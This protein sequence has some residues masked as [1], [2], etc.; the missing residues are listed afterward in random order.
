MVINNEKRRRLLHSLITALIVD[1]E[2]QIRVFMFGYPQRNVEG[3][4]VLTEPSFGGNKPN[5]CINKCRSGDCNG[6]QSLSV[7]RSYEHH[8]EGKSERRH[9]NLRLLRISRLFITYFHL[10]NY[11]YSRVWR[12]SRLPPLCCSVT[13]PLLKRGRRY[14][15]PCLRP[16][17]S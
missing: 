6:K 13:Q 10:I 4:L 1:K 14:G 7:A 5:W 8:A 15:W 16:C 17:F 12:N 3:G 2:K 11:T 9:G